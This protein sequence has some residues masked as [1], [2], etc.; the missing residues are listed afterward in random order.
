MKN[1]YTFIEKWFYLRSGH[2]LIMTM[3]SSAIVCSNIICLCLYCTVL[4]DCRGIN[5]R[6][7]GKGLFHKTVCKSLEKWFKLHNFNVTEFSVETC[8]NKDVLL[9]FGY[10]LRRAPSVRTCPC[11]L[12]KA[13][14]P[15]VIS[16]AAAVGEPLASLCLSIVVVRWPLGTA[17]SGNSR[18]GAGRFA[19]LPCS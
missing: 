16:L 12:P 2:S 19:G 11:A 4:A 1:V 18:E 10:F 5:V 8:T 3:G 15:I 9:P 6:F 14:E 17:R 7:L 13:P